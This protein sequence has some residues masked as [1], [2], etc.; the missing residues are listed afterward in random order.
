LKQI[1]SCPVAS[2]SS[3]P[4][5][6]LST[7][8][9]HVAV[10]ALAFTVPADKST[11]ATARPLFDRAGDFPSAD[12]PQPLPHPHPLFGRAAAHRRDNRLDHLGRRQRHGQRDVHQVMLAP[13]PSPMLLPMPLSS[14]P[15]LFRGTQSARSHLRVF[16][17]FGDGRRRILW[18]GR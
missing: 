9:L 2:S 4:P 3:A 1:Y 13:R 14:L 12:P 11:E 7:T 10:P 6:L 17:S 18:G 16:S 15:P 5:T 8:L